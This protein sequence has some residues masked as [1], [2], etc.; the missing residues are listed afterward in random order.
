MKGEI[1]Q[2]GESFVEVAKSL[3]GSRKTTTPIDELPDSI[4]PAVNVFNKTKG[5]QVASPFWV[6]MSKIL[7]N[8]TKCM[9]WLQIPEVTQWR[10]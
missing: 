8:K 5:V 3:I 1:T 10:G 9:I 4:K 2:C 6:D 7:E